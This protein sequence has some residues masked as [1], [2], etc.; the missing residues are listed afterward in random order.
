MARTGH[1]RPLIF[2]MPLD[3]KWA[4]SEPIV[5]EVAEKKPARSAK[6]VSTSHR[7][8]SKKK[9]GSKSAGNEPTLS[10]GSDTDEYTTDSD[11]SR[12][13]SGRKSAIFDKG[14]GRENHGSSSLTE[15]PLAKALGIS[16]D[17]PADREVPTKEPKTRQH[18]QHQSKNS[19]HSKAPQ[20]STNK[21]NKPNEKKSQALKKRIEEQK[22]KLEENKHKAEQKELINS[23]LDGDI[24]F[25]WED[26]ESELME[27]LKIQEG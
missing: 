3:S 13:N 4:T 6:K 12:P 27:K 24:S 23:L 26:D 25:D 21:A 20:E 5:E 7:F 2:A 1:T 18:Q 16:L 22:K 17:P 11:W 10:V 14:K 15:N 8:D 9:R 19:Q